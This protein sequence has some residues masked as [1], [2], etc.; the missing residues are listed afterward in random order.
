LLNTILVLCSSI[1]V[2]LER[3][4]ILRRNKMGRP[5]KKKFF[6]NLNAPYQDHATGGTTGYGGEGVASYGTIVAGSGW[7]TIPTVTV[8]PPDFSFNGAATATVRAHYKALSFATTA[9]G[10]GYA[11]ADVLEVDTGT[12]ATKARAPVA[13]IVVVGVPT[14]A[15][16]GT[17]YDVAGAVGDRVTFTNAGL[18]Q[19]LIVEITAVSGSSATTVEVVQPGI[20]VGAGAPTTTTGWTAVTSD[21]P[22]DNNGSGLVLNLAWGVYAFGTV[23]V[24]G[25]YT[26]FPS[27]G[28]SGTLTSV[29]P[30]TGTGAK[31][32]ITMGLL[33][34]DVL[35][36]GR[37][38]TVTT[39]AAIS[40]TGST[41]AAATSVLTSSYQNGLR[42]SAF[43]KGGSSAVL[44]DIMKQEASRRYL[45][46]TAQGQG[47][48][49]LVAS[50]TPAEGE[51]NLVATDTNG[52]TY[53]VT[54]LTA[55]RCI[56]TRRT[57]STAYLFATNGAAGWTISGASAGV[58]SIASV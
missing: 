50:D 19:A 55:R 8:S 43:V 22:T 49:R 14:V 23:S 51:M 26:A 54:K 31:A 17:L 44:G 12:A 53:W 5:I 16:G 9:N 57:M 21:G 1:C 18:S 35:T 20:W 33:S 41:G 40:F 11:V 56:L 24:A 36:P 27:T 7:T 15:N 2:D 34:V 4:Y 10:T 28:A 39:D 52:S 47:Q 48:C 30:A 46:K 3:H 42:I 6:A 58:V 45:V 32:D 38:Y 25:D 37:G 13:S 29:T